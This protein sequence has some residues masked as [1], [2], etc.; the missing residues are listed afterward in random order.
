[1]N[2]KRSA[3]VAHEVAMVRI[4][5]LLQGS[6]AGPASARELCSAPVFEVAALLPPLQGKQLM[7]L[8]TSSAL[9]PPCSEGLQTVAEAA[10]RRPGSWNLCELA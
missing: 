9:S 4:F 10:A 1:M 5:E 2:E 8:G 7:Y 6:H 3:L